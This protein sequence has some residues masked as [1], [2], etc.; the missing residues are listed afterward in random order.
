MTE[1][2]KRFAEFYLE[3]GNARQSAIKA[4]YSAGYAEHVKR[5]RGVKEY[6]EMR[7]D[8]M[9]R[10]RIASADEVLQFLT[11]VMRGDEK[12]EKGATLRMKAAEMISRRLG[13]EEAGYAGPAA[14]IVD[15][16]GG[17]GDGEAVSQ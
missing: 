5:Q 3:T 14:V 10:K 11:A 6:L 2:Q 7:I 17:T 4:G 13:Y 15:D 8:G 16:I 12:D 9:D 1:R